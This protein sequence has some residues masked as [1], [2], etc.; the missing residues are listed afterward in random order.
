MSREM[1]GGCIFPGGLPVFPCLNP[2][3]GFLFILPWLYLKNFPRG[4]IPRGETSPGCLHSFQLQVACKT[5]KCVHE[6]TVGRDNCPHP[7]NLPF[8]YA[9]TLTGKQ[10]CYFFLR[11]IFQGTILCYLC[12]HTHLTQLEP[13]ISLIH[14][15]E[16]HSVVYDILYSAFSALCRLRVHTC[17][18]Q[19]TVRQLK[20]LSTQQLFS[21]RCFCILLCWLLR[22][23]YS[24]ILFMLGFLVRTLYVSDTHPFVTSVMMMLRISLF[25]LQDNPQE[26]RKNQDKKW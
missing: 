20:C 25:H 9:L 12:C 23:S 6:L 14:C 3:C 13:V 4:K 1:K 16:E 19:V 10:S 22:R 8:S 26:I 11:I 17:F 5:F 21:N 2:L 15:N 7:G 18:F 24:A